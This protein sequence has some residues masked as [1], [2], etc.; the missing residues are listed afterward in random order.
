MDRTEHTSSLDGAA[1]RTA[2]HLDLMAGMTFDVELVM[3]MI[4]HVDM[5]FSI[6]LLP[7]IITTIYVL[8]KT[9]YVVQ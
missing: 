1:T 5:Y 6:V 4:L 9:R 8:Q 7:K 3:R 2:K